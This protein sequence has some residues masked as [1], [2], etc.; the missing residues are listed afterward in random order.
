M[1]EGETMGIIAFEGASA[2]GKSTTC[3]ELEK[4]YGAYIIPEVNS[5]FERPKNEHRTWYF[6]KQ[7]ERWNIAVQKSEQYELVIFDGDIYQPLSYN[8]CFHFDIFNQPLSLIENFYKEK[9]IN[10]EIGFPDQYFYL[11]TN[12]EELRKRKVSDETKRRRNFEKHLHI[13]KSFQR[14]YENLNTVTDGYC[15]LIEAKS[16]RNNE[17][18]IVRN[19][20]NLNVCEERR[21]DVSRLDAITKWLKENRA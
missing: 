12:D 2:V 7:V 4:N 18:E 16:V 19:S 15:K 14:Y 8:W 1:K 20:K 13:S 21:F 11:Y 5:L 3:R 6:E 10:R 17:L 9:M